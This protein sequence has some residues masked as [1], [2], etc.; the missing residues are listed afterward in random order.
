MDLFLLLKSMK[1]EQASIHQM[2]NWKRNTKAKRDRDSI[3]HSEV[4]ERW[5]SNHKLE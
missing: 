4:G 5:S 3:E 1:I 2:L